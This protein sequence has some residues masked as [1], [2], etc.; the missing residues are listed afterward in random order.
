M[1]KIIVTGAF[2]L[3]LVAIGCSESGDVTTSTN[4]TVNT[5]SN[6]FTYKEQLSLITVEDEDIADEFV[7]NNNIEENVED[8]NIDWTYFDALYS[9]NL[10]G[11]IKEKLGY[12]ILAKKDLIGLLKNDPTNT[13]Y[14]A[15]VKKYINI[16][17]DEKYIGFT[18]LQSALVELETADGNY[19]SYVD[20]TA[21]KIVKYGRSEYPFADIES[22]SSPSDM[23]IS[24]EE[25]DKLVQNYQDLGNI[26]LL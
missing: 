8:Q 7:I 11:D 14:I 26:E 3:F 15:A 22:Q 16:L 13:T 21:Q 12:I 20:E 19:A 1:K 5:K 18:V 2:L 10:P 6:L 4:E 17:V 24:Q 9:D 25:Y 23:G